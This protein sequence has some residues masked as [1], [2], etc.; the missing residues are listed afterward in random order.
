M[1]HRTSARAMLQYDKSGVQKR[2]FKE[3]RQVPNVDIDSQYFFAK[4]IPSYLYHFDFTAQLYIS[5]DATLVKT[6]VSMFKVYYQLKKPQRNDQL[7]REGIRGSKYS[8]GA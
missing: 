3:I 4:M 5:F 1:K 6:G 2:G 7:S 8:M